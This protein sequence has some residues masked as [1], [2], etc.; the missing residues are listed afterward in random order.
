[1]DV[2]Q[3]ITI[4]GAASAALLTAGLVLG[5]MSGVLW[6]LGDRAGA[7][8]SFGAACV[9]TAAFLMT[10]ILLVALLALGF[11]QDNM[12]KSK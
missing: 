2:R 12:E 4:V 9:S 1:M 11:L 7:Q 8:V 6:H 3:G 10:H 5:G